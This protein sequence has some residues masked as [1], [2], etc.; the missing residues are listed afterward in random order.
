MYI[1][2]KTKWGH[3]HLVEEVLAL[4]LNCH[5]AG[6][7]TRISV[8]VHP[9]Q[10]ITIC[11]DNV[12]CQLEIDESLSEAEEREFTNLEREL[13]RLSNSHGVD[14]FGASSFRGGGMLGVSIAGVT[15]LSSNLKIEACGT[16][17]VYRQSYRQGIAEGPVEVTPRTD[18]SGTR[19]TFAAD[20]EIFEDKHRKFDV[21]KIRK[22]LEMLSYL[23]A[24]LETHFIDQQTG[25]EFT[26]RFS[27]GIREFLERPTSNPTSIVVNAHDGDIRFEAAFE[28]AHRIVSYANSTRCFEGGLHLTHFFRVLAEVLNEFAQQNMNR[29][30][31]EPLPHAKL[32]ELQL[33]GIISLRMSEPLWKGA[34]KTRIENAELGEF[35]DRQIRPQLVEFF[36]DQPKLARSIDSQGCGSC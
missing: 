12:S 15:F 30:E 21:D 8:E 18:E 20:P 16:S 35:A 26:Y 17:E 1:G 5:Q 3:Y 32:Y 28:S 7:V 33:R 23:N 11:D 22:R 25:N 13:S 24:G 9:N 14:F 36:D 34:T 2:D 27:N 31:Y 10:S 6:V 19:I 4:M 29:F